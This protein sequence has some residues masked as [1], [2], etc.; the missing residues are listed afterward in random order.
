V[1]FDSGTL[2]AI[3]AG[4]Q[5]TAKISATTASTADVGAAPTTVV[6]AALLGVAVGAPVSN[7]AST[8]MLTRG[9]FCGRI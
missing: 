6:Q 5:V 2:T 9:T 4:D 8:V 3:A 1:L 7:T